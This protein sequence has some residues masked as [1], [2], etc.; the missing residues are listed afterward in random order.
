MLELSRQVLNVWFRRRPY[1]EPNLTYLCQLRLSSFVAGYNSM[2][3][4]LPL[5]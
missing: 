2:H 1:L 5:E 4:F 3:V